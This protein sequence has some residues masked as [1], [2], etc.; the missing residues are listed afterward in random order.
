MTALGRSPGRDDAHD[1]GDDGAAAI[2]LGVRVGPRSPLH[3]LL[4][5]LP[6]D[7]EARTLLRL[8]EAGAAAG[9]HDA[10]PGP[11]GSGGAARAT[12]PDGAAEGSA[13]VAALAR[14]AEAVE[15]LA[16]GGVCPAPAGEPEPA[17][18]SRADRLDSAWGG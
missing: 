18:P 13:L 9:V 16:D 4:A 15:R 2:R 3:P 7:A 12:V 6:P 17:A 5:A 14:I 11:Q 1:G 8:A 10:D